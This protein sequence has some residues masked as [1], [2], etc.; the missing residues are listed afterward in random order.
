MNY[1]QTGTVDLTDPNGYEPGD[2]EYNVIGA[3]VR[4]VHA[5]T[6]LDVQHSPRRSGLVIGPDRDAISTSE[7][8]M[9]A[10]DAFFTELALA[11]ETATA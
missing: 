8:G 11:T 4:Y 7:T 6:G 1:D 9:R 2:R 10:S 3:Q 5:V